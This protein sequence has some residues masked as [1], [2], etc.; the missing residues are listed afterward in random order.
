M[1]TELLSQYSRLGKLKQIEQIQ[2]P[3]PKLDNAAVADKPTFADF[4]GQKIG[5][6]NDLGLKADAAI[7]DKLTGK[8]VN[9]HAAMIAMQKADI[10]F[11]LLM[12]VQRRVT[13][14]YEQIIR[15]PIG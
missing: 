5:D 12:S 15:M 4:L 9:P 8:E 10:S 11:R 7:Q 6:V 13:Q 2:G 3:Q 1:K 14:A